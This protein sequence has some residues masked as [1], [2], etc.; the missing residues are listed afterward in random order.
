MSRVKVV[1]T[2]REMTLMLMVLAPTS[3]STTVSPGG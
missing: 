2:V 1:I 3:M